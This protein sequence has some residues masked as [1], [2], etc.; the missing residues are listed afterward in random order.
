MEISWH[1]PSLRSE[2]EFSSVSNLEST[3]T[4][5]TSYEPSSHNLSESMMM[6]RASPS[7][8]YPTE[9]VQNS[10]SYFDTP[11][12]GE[13]RASSPA[14]S[15]LSDTPHFVPDVLLCLQDGCSKTFQGKYRRGTRQRHMRLKH[16]KARGLEEK[17]Y[18]CEAFGCRKFYMRQDARL[19]HY[20]KQHPELNPSV[21]VRRK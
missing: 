5:L 3:L 9:I 15:L 19:K 13:H 14:C 8:D 1:F 20:R 16:G 4:S 11:A 7:S 6:V 18:P 21:V 2:G 10:R 17:E 12:P